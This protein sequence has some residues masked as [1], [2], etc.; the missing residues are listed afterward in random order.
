MCRITRAAAT[1]GH[2]EQGQRLTL[3]RALNRVGLDQRAGDG[4]V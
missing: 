3:R 4:D 1:I 2:I